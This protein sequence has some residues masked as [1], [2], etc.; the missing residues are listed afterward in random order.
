MSVA[1]EVIENFVRDGERPLSIDDPLL[2]GERMSELVEGF[3]LL[4]R[5]TATNV[6]KLIFGASP[7][8]KVKELAT[9]Y[10]A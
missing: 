10:R 6:S 8:E 2:G 7:L 4:Q 1:A 5:S 9:E 3:R